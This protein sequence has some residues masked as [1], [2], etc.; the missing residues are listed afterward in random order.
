MQAIIKEYPIWSISFATFSLLV[1]LLR[2]F[3]Q[4]FVVYP[5][6]LL[7]IQLLEEDIIVKTR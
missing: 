1:V 2:K 4:K 7:T 5:C 3:H 6:K